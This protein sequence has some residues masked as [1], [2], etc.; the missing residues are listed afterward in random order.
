MGV[1]K[2]HPQVTQPKK[3]KSLPEIPNINLL[4][5]MTRPTIPLK[6]EDPFNGLKMSS[7]EDGSSMLE[8][9]EI[10]RIK[11]ERE[12]LDQRFLN[13]E[14]RVTLIL[15]LLLILSAKRKLIR[16]LPSLK[17]LLLKKK[18]RPRRLL[19]LAKLKKN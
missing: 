10:S 12:K 1:E 14:T 8:R 15:K 3:R 5:P 13:S 18:L 9:R 16:R 4:I 7:R 17:V 19:M 11:L 6:P 2:C